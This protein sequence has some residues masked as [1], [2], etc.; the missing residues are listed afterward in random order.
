MRPGGDFPPDDVV[1]SIRGAEHLSPEQIADVIS[2]GGRLVLFEFCISLLVVTLRC[3]TRVYLLRP[4]QFGVL[5]GLPYT[6][7]TFLLGWW[8]LPWGIVYTPLVLVN[9]LCGGS[10]V[11]AQLWPSLF[12]SADHGFTVVDDDEPLSE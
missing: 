3:P 1:A 10:D 6:L 7:L 11:T 9:N 2:N 5:V 4:G 8:G 12:P